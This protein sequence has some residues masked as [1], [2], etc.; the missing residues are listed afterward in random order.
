MIFGKQIR[1]RIADNKANERCYQ[2]DYER[3]AKYRQTTACIAEKLRKMFK[4]SAV[5]SSVKNA[6]ISMVTSGTTTNSR[7]K[8]MYG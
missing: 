6:L 2:S 4:G 3:V 5:L 7:R 8:I 1:A